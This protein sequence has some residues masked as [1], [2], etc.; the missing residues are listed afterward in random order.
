LF[1]GN[2]GG[3]FF[4]RVFHAI[5]VGHIVVD[6]N[7]RSHCDVMMS[8]YDEMSLMKKR[9]QKNTIKIS[10]EI[11]MNKSVKKKKKNINQSSKEMLHR[12]RSIRNQNIS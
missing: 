8:C 3:I 9:V 2:C 6:V 12:S 10:K 1:L 7:N 11:A 4:I 5:F